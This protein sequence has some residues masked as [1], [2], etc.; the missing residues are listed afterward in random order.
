MPNLTTTTAYR[1]AGGRKAVAVEALAALGAPDAGRLAAALAYAAR[2]WRV[3]PLHTP[4]PGGG[5]SC[6]DRAC[7]SP[8]KHP[9]TMHGLR[10]ATTDEEAIRRWWRMWPDANVGIATGDGLAVLDVDPR[11][12][13]DASL[14]DLEDRYGEIRTLI[15]RT[16]GGG[17]HLYLAAP[18][19]LRTRPG[20]LPGLDL[21]AA[22]GYVVAPPSLHASGRRYEWVPDYPEEPQPMPGWLLDL[23]QER[24]RVNGNGAA[25]PADDIIPEGRRNETLTSLAGTMRRRGMEEPE[26]LAALR[27]VNARRCRPPLPD[28]EVAAIA[29]SVARYAPG[30]APADDARGGA[31]AATEAA[32]APPVLRLP[33]LPESFWNERAA[34]A[35]IRDAAWSR[36]RA[37][38]AVLFATMARI[39]AFRP[40]MMR[41]D[42]GIASPASLNL[43]VAL[44]DPSGGGKSS[45]EKIA[46]RVLPAPEEYQDVDG[47]PI[48]SGEGMAE[49]YMGTVLEP[50]PDD[51]DKKDRVRKQVR[52]NALFYADEGQAFTRLTERNGSTLGESLRR[53]FNGETLG[54]TNA[55]QDRVR[56]VRDYSLG[57]I[58]GMQ[59]EAALALLA[60]APYGT[61][62][63]FLWCG[64]IDPTIPDTPPPWPGE[65]RLSLLQ[66]FRELTIDPDICAE[67]RRQ[68]LARQRGELVR[69]PLDAHEPLLRIKV[70]A[71]LAILDGRAH[72]TRDDWRL[73]GIVYETSAAVRNAIVE[74]GRAV[75]RARQLEERREHAAR[76]VAA[77]RALARERAAVE[78]VAR[79]VSR[80]VL[81][82][83]PSLRA[84]LTRAVAGRDRRYLER[85][86][87]HAVREGWIVEGEDGRYLPGRYPAEAA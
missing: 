78:R 16:G 14:A 39:A 70:A 81:K 42:T 35:H 79:I 62:Q 4:Q 68:D 12:D 46:R 60:E 77:D 26:I 52:Y 36:N 56:R 57:L 44:V 18:G 53:A 40:P 65:L 50:R 8:G 13:G 41:V 83:G 49:A 28:D 37:P 54:H 22:G 48:G 55:S 1:K 58:I 34:L 63:R 80:R 25:P 21:K 75:A 45:A 61:P 67:L 6:R 84:D 29:R 76:A 71:I 32:A 82:H 38:D 69:D 86:I 30:A 20:F 51:P 3:L 11:N 17:L 19:D 31:D 5:C 74:Y 73:A 9:R 72:I 85:A 24:A 33:R 64:V 10:D 2:G 43:L 87:E 7:A 27:E 23:V 66:H 59:P 47:L 15:A